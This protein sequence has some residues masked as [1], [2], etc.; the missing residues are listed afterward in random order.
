MALASPFDKYEYLKVPF[1]LTQ[2]S[3]YLQELMNKVLK[4]LLFSIA[5]LDDIIFYSKTIKDHLSHLEQVFLWTPE[6]KTVHE[7]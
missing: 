7:T 6:H 2:A 1:W 3:A 5:F 4:D